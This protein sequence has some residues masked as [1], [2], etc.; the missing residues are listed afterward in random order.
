MMFKTTLRLKN[1]LMPMLLANLP[2]ELSLTKPPS[3]SKSLCLFTIASKE[4]LHR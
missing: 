2:D 3:L 4:K 1:V